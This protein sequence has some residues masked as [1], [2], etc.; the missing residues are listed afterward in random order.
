MYEPN[1]FLPFFAYRQFRTSL[2]YYIPGALIGQHL[3][4]A[5]IGRG[6]LKIVCCT[7]FLHHGVVVVVFVAKFNRFVFRHIQLRKK[8]GFFQHERPFVDRYVMQRCDRF[9]LVI[10]KV[11]YFLLLCQLP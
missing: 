1:D 8:L 11:L 9:D 4:L 10:I 2:W 7:L 5:L 3:L 6:L